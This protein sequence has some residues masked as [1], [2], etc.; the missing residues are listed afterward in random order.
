MRLLKAD[1]VNYR[2]IKNVSIDFDPVCRVLVGINESGKSNI[3]NALALLDPA[4]PINRK[5][6]VRDSGPTEAEV[7]EA[8]VRFSFRLEKAEADEVF[9][10]IGTSVLST[11]HDPDIASIGGSATRL[12]ALC[13]QRTDVRYYVDLMANKREFRYFK[14]DASLKLLGNWKKPA[15][16][17]PATFNVTLEGSSVAMS[18]YKLI[19]A[20]DLPEVP[21][22]YLEDATIDDLIVL[23]GS[24]AIKV[25]TGCAPQSLLWEYDEANLL[26][27]EIPIA[28]FAANPAA[29]IPLKNMFLLGGVTD[30][31][32]ELT[33]IK[34][35]SS[36]R[37]QNFL[38]RIAAKTTAHFRS[39]WKEYKDIAFQL[40][41]E[42]DRIVPAIKE[43]NSFD[44][45][46]RSDGFKRF[47]TFLLLIS[48]DVKLNAL[49]D[50]LVLIDEPEI[51]LHPSGARYLRD[52][53]IRISTKNYVVYSTHSIFMIDAGEIDRHYIVK[54]KAEIT[55]VET[56]QESNI[57]DEE[58]LFNALGFSMFEAL[59]PMNII[60]EGWRDK[61]LFI[62]AL[63]R[64]PADTRRKLKEVGYCHAKGVANI[65]TIT[66]LIALANRRCIILSDSAVAARAQQR[67]YVNS[68]GFG[69]W[70]VYQDMTP[71]VEAVT[72]EDF[73]KNGRIVKCVNDVAGPLGLPTF[74]VA[75]LPPGGKLGA[76]GSWMKTNG[77]NEP[78]VRD[79][80]HHA[81]ELIFEALP[82]KDIDDKYIDY[83][84]AVA[85][86][87]QSKNT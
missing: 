49:T 38:D 63:E 33:R 75:D 82:A 77:L 1:I 58:V 39:V 20:S 72:G 22:G 6:D 60:F 67:E 53:L 27:N 51:G 80:V 26:P 9:E 12:K 17:C 19:R 24:A 86:L 40:R 70:K 50:T 2:S 65:K 68:K 31:A 84:K 57:A 30:I 35:L 81:K 83:V 21:A 48:V 69:E 52:E 43:E 7:K 55:T 15:K 78:Q 54:K 18:S 28:T 4:L 13:N 8:Y 87:V 23:I 37:K 79:A 71:S 44:F 73:I 14:A 10:A 66:P 34:D 25:A 74:T 11:A 76:V 85:A 5:D 41:L 36:N 62:A 3:L 46:R 64:A 32:G 16:A 56:A 61:A 45:K 59:K 29:C 42:G 47:V